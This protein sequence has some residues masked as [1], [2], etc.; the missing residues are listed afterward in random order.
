[1]SRRVFLILLAA[2]VA[3]TAAGYG[4]TAPG[5]TIAIT[6]VKVV[7]VAGPDLALGTILIKDG[8]IADIGAGIAVPPGA[9]VVEG[10]GLTAF[11]GMIDG[12]SF[13]GLQEIT[14]VIETVDNRETG[15]I[16]PQVWA[17]EA[18]RYDSMHIP[19]ARSNG[20]TAAIVAPTGGLISGRSV[21]IKLEGWTNREMV[22]RNPAALQIE[23]PGIQSGR[24]GA[25]GFGQRGGGGGAL[26]AAGMIAELK[27]LFA[28][29]R[30]YEKR[31]AYAKKNLSV[32]LPD[33][34]ET[35]EFLLPVLKGDVAVMISVHADRD[36]QAAV[37]FVKDEGLKAVFYGAEQGWK[38]ANDIKASGIPVII[39]PLYASPPVWDDGYD[40]LFMNA[41]RL[42]RAGI[43]IAFSSGSA[44][45]AKDLPYHAAKAA[46][47]GLER[48]EALRAVTLSPAEIFGVAGEMGS[49][50]KGKAANIVLADGDILEMRTNI[51]SV[52]IDGKPCDMSN[53]YTELLEKFKKR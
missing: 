42:A 3:G 5:K 36:I 2:L 16:N 31:K 52:F 45:A 13:L 32:A 41:V 39:S 29:A 48:R 28:K 20:I 53:R 34:D 47:F 4:Q 38:V 14:G 25:G 51:K 17:I 10:R 46:A 18:L 23:F 21:L 8:K 12:Y 1:M 22:V 44:T 11:P 6:N 7:P 35:S 19:I 9:E 50:E 33:F 15:R 30:A 49:L 40:Q 27:E 43:K 37:R 26:N 24:G